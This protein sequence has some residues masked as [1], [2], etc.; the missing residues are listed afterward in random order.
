MRDRIV[1]IAGMGEHA[2]EDGLLGN[3]AIA[4]DPDGVN[5]LRLLGQ[6]GAGGE[7]EESA[8]ERAGRAGKGIRDLREMTSCLIFTGL[9]SCGEHKYWCGPR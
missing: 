1:D 5:G 7:L 6:S 8:P 2:G 3:T 9:E 4:D